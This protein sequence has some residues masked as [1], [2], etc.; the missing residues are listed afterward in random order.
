MGNVEMN[1]LE[2]EKESENAQQSLERFESIFPHEQACLKFFP[3]D[4]KGCGAHNAEAFDLGKREFDC[5]E[6]NTKTWRTA[7]TF[8]HGRKYLR[9]VFGAIW[10]N[11]ERVAIST[12]QFSKIFNIAY[13]S[14]YATMERIHEV[15]Q[16]EM[17]KH[18]LFQLITDAFNPV[19]CKRSKL[20]F[21][22]EHPDYQEE[23]NKPDEDLSGTLDADQLAVCNA[24][25]AHPC[26][27]D[28]LLESSGLSVAKFSVT[29]A[30]LLLLGLAKQH[31]G[32]RYSLLKTSPVKLMSN[33]EK[34]V[35]KEFLSYIRLFHG[36]SRKHLQRYVAAFWARYWRKRWSEPTLFECCLKYERTKSPQ[37]STRDIPRMV[38]VPMP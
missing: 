26:S 28:E 31:P 15:F 36:V 35:L 33:L 11:E 32:N 24:L 9:P 21:S 13:A 14:G 16:N 17:E 3:A 5:T 38:L 4:C 8:F 2:R 1:K 10:L 25:K 18:R 22:G 7:G 29:I 20:S 34:A 6:C 37:R 27:F 12:N 30:S 23:D 19:I